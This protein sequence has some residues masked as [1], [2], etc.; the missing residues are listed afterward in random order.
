MKHDIIWSAV[1]NLAK[2]HN[3]STSKLAKIVGLDATTFNKSKRYRKDGKKRWPSLKSINKILSFYNLNFDDFYGKSALDGFSSLPIT[4]ISS[5]EKSNIKN[6]N[7]QE[8]GQ[9]ST[10]NLD[11]AVLLDTAKYEPIYKYNATLILSSI[12]DIRRGDRVFIINKNKK[13]DL[14]EFV[15][16]IGDSYEFIS[17]SAPN[18]KTEVLIEDIILIKRIIWASQ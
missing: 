15:A 5:I 9:E 18:K 11:F 10:S 16:S 3:I 13:V 17:L 12:I 6:A 2:T 8:M 4:N 7:W 1:D 14:Y